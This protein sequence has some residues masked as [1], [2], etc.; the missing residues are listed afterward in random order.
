MAI[1][2]S[3]NLG[4]EI[5]SSFINFP[6]LIGKQ[7]SFPKHLTFNGGHFRIPT[8]ADSLQSNFNKQDRLTNTFVS[9]S[10]IEYKKKEEIKYG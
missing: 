2:K 9:G 8:L 4:M 3:L 10:I 6:S 7:S 1:E 5:C